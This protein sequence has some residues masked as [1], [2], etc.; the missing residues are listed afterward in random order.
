MLARR[1]KP[2]VDAIL[3][4]IRR[5]IRLPGFPLVQGA[6]E[7]FGSGG[8]EV[9]GVNRRGFDGEGEGDDAAAGPAAQPET[10]MRFTQVALIGAERLV[11][12]AL[13]SFDQDAFAR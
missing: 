13:F 3:F 6:G 8:G 12:G 2:G 1:K 5:K 10:A 7:A 4:K 9:Q 11:G